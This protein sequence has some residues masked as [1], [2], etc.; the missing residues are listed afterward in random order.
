MGRFEKYLAL[1]VATCM[2]I[3]LLLS[4][5]VPGVSEAINGWQVRGVSI[6]IGICLF[7]MMYPAMLN[8][9]LAELRKLRIN[10]KPI[11]ITL[12]SNWIVAP[13]TALG[14]AS[15]FLRG[16]EQLMV[17]VILLGAS[18]CT[19]MVLVWGKLAE[20][21][22]E[23]NVVNTS[24]NTVTI[25]FLYVPIVSLLTGLRSIP[26]DRVLLAVSAGIF[27]GAPLL[28]GI[29][30]KRF[31]VRAKGEKWFG[32]VYKPVV[33]RI[34]IVALLLTL[35]VLFALNGNVLLRHFDPGKFIIKITP[36]NPTHSTARNE[37]TSYVDPYDCHAESDRL[38][39]KL[40]AAGY[41]VLLSIGEVEENK[42]GSNC[43]Q[44]L[45]RHLRSDESLED[46]YTYTVQAADAAT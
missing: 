42:I 12:V 19:A 23:Q 2:G 32:Q 4:Q 25:M 45:S 36:I 20:G 22:Q 5:T 24:L 33:G 3:G 18:P 9:Q 44:Y 29:L 8:L 28:I 30:S 31:L 1:W 21:N 37:L 15:L 35:V 14:L 27:I 26:I 13:L 17:A 39:Q 7:L 6:P 40:R 16:N 11:L 10:P 34:S 43:G 46:A 41:Q 38:L